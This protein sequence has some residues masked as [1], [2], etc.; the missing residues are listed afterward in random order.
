MSLSPYNYVAN[1][2]IIFIDPDGREIKISDKSDQKY[3]L[4]ELQTVIGSETDR[5][6]FNKKGFLKVKKGGI[7]KIKDQD[8]KD[9]LTGFHEI[10]KDNAIIE[11]STNVKTVGGKNIVEWNPE[12]LINDKGD[13]QS[14]SAYSKPSQITLGSEGVFVGYDFKSPTTSGVRGLVAMDRKR[15]ATATFNSSSTGKT[16]TPCAGCILIHEFLDHGREFIATKY[17]SSKA[18]M[19]YHNKALNLIKSLLRPSKMH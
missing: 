4:T 18:G 17:K 19:D 14:K 16:T 11:F 15:S 10:T 7:K 8:I 2:P 12:I 1:N 5:F 3:F 9:I 13:W 6:K